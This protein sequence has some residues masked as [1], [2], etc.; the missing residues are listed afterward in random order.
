MKAE[1]LIDARNTLGESVNWHAAE[2]VLYWTDVKGARLWRFDPRTGA[3]ES[4]DMPDK[5]ATFALCSTPGVVLV[6][7][8]ESLAFFELASS[9]LTPLHSI[10]LGLTTRVNDGRCDR[11]GCFVFGTQDDS[12]DP[13]PMAAFYRLNVDLSLERL[14]LLRPAISNSI[15]FSPDGRTMYYCDSPNRVI[16]CCDYSAAGAISNDRVFVRLT[17]ADGVPDG[18]T[19]DAEGGLWNAQFGGARVLRYAPDGLESQRIDVPTRQPTCV[20]LGGAALDTLFITSSREGMSSAAL[21]NDPTAG[22]VYATQVSVRGLP[23]ACFAGV[24]PA[25]LHE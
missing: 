5:L 8:A 1:L 20:S 2:G 24:P 21:R 15:S 18:S 14:P 6:G 10:E 13:R 16:R 22:G 9:R 4:W 19:V 12:D 17:D 25:A 11:R 7:L 23:E 3:R